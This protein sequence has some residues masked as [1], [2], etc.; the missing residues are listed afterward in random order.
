MVEVGDISSFWECF[1]C[2]IAARDLR[3]GWMGSE[4]TVMATEEMEKLRCFYASLK[5]ADYNKVN[6]QF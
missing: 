4:V 6:E 3:D 1:E 2:L 5:H